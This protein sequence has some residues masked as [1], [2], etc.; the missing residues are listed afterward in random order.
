MIDYYLIFSNI[1]I[2]NHVPGQL[3]QKVN[4]ITYFNGINSREFQIK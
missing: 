4:C 2:S 3:C 1:G